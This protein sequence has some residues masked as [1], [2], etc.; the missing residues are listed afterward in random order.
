MTTLPKILTDDTLLS[1]KQAAQF[2]GCS[3]RQIP[4]YVQRG[5]PKVAFGPRNVRYKIREL[6]KFTDKFVETIV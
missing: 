1:R 4:R 5:L 6:K 3:E 2:L